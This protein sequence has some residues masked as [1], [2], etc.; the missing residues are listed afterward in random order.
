MDSIVRQ[1]YLKML[2]HGPRPYFDTGLLIIE[3]EDLDLR[4]AK[5]LLKYLAG[6]SEDMPITS[7]I[8]R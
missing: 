3:P 8:I 4:D 7:W 6:G 2:R 1:I 5:D